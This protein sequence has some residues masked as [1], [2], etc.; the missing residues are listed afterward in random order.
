MAEAEIL[1]MLNPHPHIIK[2]LGD[3]YG[4]TEH[5]YTFCIL[6]EFCSISLSHIILSR[7]G[8][9]MNLE[10]S[11]DIF[12]QVKPDCSNSGFVPAIIREAPYILLRQC[13]DLLD[14]SHI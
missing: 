13:V 3:S 8:K 7:K 4:Q 6:I 2:Y 11:L 12:V 14:L 5:G 10:T 1:R 9:L